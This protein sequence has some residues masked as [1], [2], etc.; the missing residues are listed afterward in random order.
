MFE[1]STGQKD[2][3]VYSTIST[4]GGD[5]SIKLT[6]IYFIRNSIYLS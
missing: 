2:G 5:E 1:K 3:Q 6:C 4:V